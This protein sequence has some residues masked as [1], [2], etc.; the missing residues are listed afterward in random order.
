MKKGII[1]GLINIVSFVVGI[2][3]G[4]KMLVGMINDYK[5]R[6]QRNLSNM[7]LFNNWL[8][9]IYSGGSIDQYFHNHGYKKIMI[10]GNGYIGKRL[11]QALEKTDID[12]VAIMDKMNCSDAE[13]ILIGVDS[14]IPDIDCVIITP[15]FYHN[16]IYDMLRKKIKVPTISIEALWE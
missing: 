5:M 6:M 9:F 16:E 8:E 11:Y 4:G 7:M 12:V 10:Y 2:I 14:K 3:L 1:T 13:R 15:I